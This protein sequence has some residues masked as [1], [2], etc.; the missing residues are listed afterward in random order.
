MPPLVAEILTASERCHVMVC[1]CRLEWPR[2]H[3]FP[4]CTLKF[5]DG[6]EPPALPSATPPSREQELTQLAESLA[7]ADIQRREEL[8]MRLAQEV[9]ICGVT[10]YD[11]KQLLTRDFL[12]VCVCAAVGGADVRSCRRVRLHQHLLQTHADPGSGRSLGCF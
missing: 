1:V 3:Y 9:G 8:K 7:N 10:R 4:S 2:D 5:R 6:W 12:P 11:R